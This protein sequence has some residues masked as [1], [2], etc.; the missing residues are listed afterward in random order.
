MKRRLRVLVLDQSRGVWGA[1]NYLLRLAPLMRERGVELVVASPSTLG[2][3][4]AWGE[5]GFEAV[6]LELPVDRNIRVNGRPTLAGTLRE[7]RAGLRTA[8]KI[9]ALARAGDYDAIW[10][11]AHWTHAE[12]SVAGRICRRPVVLHLHEE[13]IPGVGQLLRT[14]AVAF[15]TRTVSVCS[16][17]AGDLPRFAQK[18][19]C[20]IPNGVDTDKFSPASAEHLPGL[21]RIR[22]EL[23]V[24]A[25]DVMVL[26]ATR[27]D[28]SKRI[29]DLIQAVRPIDHPRIKLVVAGATSEYPRYERAIRELAGDAPAGR[30]SFCGPRNDMAALCQASDIVIHAGVVEGMPLTLLEAQS[31]GKPVIAYDAAGVGEAVIDGRT[32][33][34]VTP[35]F[36]QGLRRMLVKLAADPALQAEMGAAARVYVLAHHRLKDQ[37]ERNVDVLAE[38]CSL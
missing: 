28:P 10:A 14:G 7:G 20:V 8:R 30:V 15:A 26:A 18:R 6:D 23:G 12:A 11:N 19:V 33:F 25:D 1:Q 24:A 31:C 4:Q 21:Q 5:A 36:V 16:A 3:T 32:G 22:H 34:L 35:Y 2:L 29:E 37:A 27:L 38:M 9:A 13:A 17:V